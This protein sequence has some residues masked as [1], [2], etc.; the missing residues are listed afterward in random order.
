[1][2]R[3]QVRVVENGLKV[4]E[5]VQELNTMGYSG[6]N[7][8]V[9]AHDDARTETLA[10]GTDASEIGMS[11]EGVM[12]S[13]ANLFRSRGDELRSKIESMGLS[14]EEAA[15]YEKELDAGRVLV[16]AK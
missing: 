9:L 3:V 10:K 12:D 14:T 16:I 2:E 6:D 1:M 15:K 5:T 11:E 8:Y 4:K 13:V 7:I